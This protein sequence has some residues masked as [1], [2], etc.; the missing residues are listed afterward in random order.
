MARRASMSASDPKRTFHSE[1]ND[2]SF[3]S[4]KLSF[5][6]YETPHSLWLVSRR[7]ERKSM[8]CATQVAT[9]IFSLAGFCISESSA[10]T[11]PVLAWVSNETATP[12][13]LAIFKQGLTELGY[14]DGK[15][16]KIEYRRAKKENRHDSIIDYILFLK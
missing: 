4:M 10:Q 9:V 5:H 15:N 3:K 2:L 8:R 7:P 12:E 14:V 16:I 11:V 13:R 6:R 1:S